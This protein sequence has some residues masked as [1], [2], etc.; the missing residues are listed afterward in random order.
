MAIQFWMTGG[1]RNK[2]EKGKGGKYQYRFSGETRDDENKTTPQNNRPQ[3]K[4]EKREKK[5]WRPE[6]AGDEKKKEKSRI[7]P[8]GQAQGKR[9]ENQVEQNWRL[10]EGESW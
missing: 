6:K 2:N 5:K 4:R 9:L 1:I 3:T 10:K 7:L 8:S